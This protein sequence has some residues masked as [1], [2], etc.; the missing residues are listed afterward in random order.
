MQGI[1]NLITDSFVYGFANIV[2]RFIGFLLM[3]LYT[4]IL[5]P[6][7]YGVLNVINITLMLVTMFSVLGLDGASHIFFWDR[8]DEN[9][10][11]S[12]FSTWFWSQA[13]TSIFLMIV[14]WLASN[15][16]SLFLFNSSDYT[17]LFR[18]SAFILLHF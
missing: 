11:M 8:K 6:Q 9:Y 17:S 1:K 12:V 10:R 2:S 4:R 5:T 7:D 13:F 14:L 15:T 3:P 18:I 16:L